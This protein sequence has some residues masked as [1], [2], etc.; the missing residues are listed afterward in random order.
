VQRSAAELGGASLVAGLAVVDALEKLGV[1]GLALKWPNDVLLGGAKLGGILIEMT[2][3][4]SVGVQLVVGIGLNVALPDGVRANLPQGVADLR[5]AGGAFSRNV[6]AGGVVSSVV[7][8][9]GHFGDRG[10]DPFM[11]AFDA[12]HRFHGQPVALQHGDETSVGRVMGVSGRGGLLLE[13]ADGT[14]EF[15]G[16]EVSL[17]QSPAR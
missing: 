17:R 4:A 6:V 12:R 16:G 3:T 14:R 8:F 10:F 15:H 9:L 13:M 1:P 2:T 7:Q 11:K 5:S